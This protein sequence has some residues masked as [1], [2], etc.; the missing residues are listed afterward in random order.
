M[1]SSRRRCI[2]QKPKTNF[3][4]I[5]FLS[6]TLPG[7]RFLLSNLNEIKLKS[8]DF[9]FWIWK[10]RAKTTLPKNKTESKHRWFSQF[11]CQLATQQLSLSWNQFCFCR[12]FNPE[13]I[14]K[15]MAP[16]L[17]K[18]KCINIEILILFLLCTKRKSSN[19]IQM[20]FTHKPLVW[21]F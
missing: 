3:I 18:Q 5:C 20:I 4:R 16:F 6:R 2:L 13:S 15:T 14:F 1:L 17:E 12:K 8:E 19:R 9:T 21:E 7:F 10:T 11:F